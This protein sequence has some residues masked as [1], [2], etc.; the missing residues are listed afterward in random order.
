[1][2][3]TPTQTTAAP[4]P[5][6]LA[7]GLIWGIKGSFLS[8]LMRMPDL[9]SSVTKAAVT[10]GGGFFFPLSSQHEYDPSTGQGTL[11]FE[12]DVRF[13]GHHGMLFVMFANPWVTFEDDRATLCFADPASHPALDQRLPMAD[14]SMRGWS[15]HLGARAW[16]G[17]PAVLREDA[18]EFFNGVY[19]A[20]E[21]M[22]PVD[23]RVE[24]SLDS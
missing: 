11:K 17:T 16:P 19:P 18:L 2:E 1:M 23:I 12:G 22:E 7:S 4:S 9:K 3:T 5:G 14:L 21:P 15:E 10:S 24:L 8:Y 20:G 13:S 6:Q